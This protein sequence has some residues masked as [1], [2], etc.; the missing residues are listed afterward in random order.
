M[1]GYR[2]YIGGEEPRKFAGE[3]PSLAAARRAAQGN[4]EGYVIGPDGTY[5]SLVEEPEI[6]TP[7]KK[8]KK[9]LKARVFGSK[10]N[11]KGHGFAV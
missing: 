1:S 11:S 7:V 2:T 5:Y 3:H 6:G 8:P 10:S 9:S 4:K